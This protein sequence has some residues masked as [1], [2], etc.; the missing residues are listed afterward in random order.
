MGVIHLFLFLII[1]FNENCIFFFISNFKKRHYFLNV[2]LL[3]YVLDSNDR[4][5]IEEAKKEFEKVLTYHQSKQ[6]LF[7]LN[8]QDIEN[9]MKEKEFISLFEPEKY[10]IKYFILKTSSVTKEGLPNFIEKI[11][12]KDHYIKIYQKDGTMKIIN[13]FLIIPNLLSNIFFWL[14]K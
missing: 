8:K 6:V 14:T 10:D 9:S 2:D 3:I 1:K 7:V 5:R 11:S 4:R 12:M 13:F